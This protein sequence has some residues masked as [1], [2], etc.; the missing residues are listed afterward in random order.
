M[1]GSK[2]VNESDHAEDKLFPATV[3]HLAEVGL[4]AQM[5]L[6]VGIASGTP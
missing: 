2:C 4:T 5:S 6:I 1:N 3:T